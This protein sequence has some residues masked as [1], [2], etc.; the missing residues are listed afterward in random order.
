MSNIQLTLTASMVLLLVFYLRFFRNRVFNAFFFF[1]FFLMGIVLILHPNI[2][3]RAAAFFGVGRGVDLIFYFLFVILFFL[4]ITIFYK[5]RNL[6]KTI[7]DL[8]RA[9]AIEEAKDLGQRS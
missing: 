7:I 4:F 2:S 8:V 6:G 1:C 9:R 5:M 3:Q